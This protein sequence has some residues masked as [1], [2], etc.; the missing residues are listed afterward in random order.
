MHIA[1]GLEKKIILLNNIFNEHEFEL[2]G[3]GKIIQPEV[4]CLG[5]YKT[6]C[7]KNCMEMINPDRVIPEIG[8]LLPY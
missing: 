7:S 6:E 3:L 8:N 1:I 5:C 2:Y 4:D